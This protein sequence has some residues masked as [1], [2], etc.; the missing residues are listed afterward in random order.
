MILAEVAK[1]IRALRKALGD[2][3][4]REFAQL[5]KVRHA[6]VSEWESAKNFPSAESFLALGNLAEGQEEKLWF[7]EQAGLSRVTLVGLCGKIAA[8]QWKQPAEGEIIRI[9]EFR[10]TAQGREEAG[11]P[12]PLP[13]RFI[14]HPERTICMSVD[15]QSIGIADSPKG[16]FILDTS[17]EGAEDLS[18]LWGRVVILRYIRKEESSVFA[19]GIYAGRLVLNPSSVRVW[20]DPNCPRIPAWLETLSSHPESGYTMLFL[21]H[22]ADP[23]GMKGI[24]PGD[25]DGWQK[26]REEIEARARSE[27]RLPAGTLIL[28][29]VQGRLSGHLEKER[30]E[31]GG[32]K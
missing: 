4:Q 29:K 30:A 17:Y 28:G 27:F 5:I 22:Y 9:P 25:K 13:S 11:P 18:A 12:V 31:G 1:R 20:A 15:E 14:P 2:V 19:N 24:A 3:G 8:E 16:I 32:E 7:W 6:T 23:Q 26:R 21:G 10:M